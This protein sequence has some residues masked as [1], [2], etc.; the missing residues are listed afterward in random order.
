[1]FSPKVMVVTM[2]YVTDVIPFLCKL[3]YCM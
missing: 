2:Q 3:T 1:M